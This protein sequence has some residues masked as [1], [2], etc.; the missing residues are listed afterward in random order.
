[1]DEKEG[2]QKTRHYAVEEEE[3]QEEVNRKTRRRKR[4]SRRSCKTKNK[5][6][7]HTCLVIS[8][9]KAAVILCLDL[10]RTQAVGSL[11]QFQR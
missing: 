5:N 2:T 10:T 1:M 8:T 7:P 11:T 9:F 6:K 3:C 4:K